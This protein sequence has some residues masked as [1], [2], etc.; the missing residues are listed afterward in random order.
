MPELDDLQRD[1]PPHRR[2]LV[3]HPDHSKSAFAKL[4]AQ[5]VVAD[6]ISR[7]LRLQPR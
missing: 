2:L 4:L 6:G 7:F 1:A 5:L 3:C